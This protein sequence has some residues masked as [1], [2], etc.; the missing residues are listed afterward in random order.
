MPSIRLQIFEQIAVLLN[1]TGKPTTL[2]TVSHERTHPIETADLDAILIYA[3]DDAPKPLAGQE[4]KAP[5]TERQ[6]SIIC[7]CRALGTE[8]IT[9]EQAL[10]PLLVW[11][12]QQII[13]NE[14]FDGLANGVVEQRTVWLSREGEKPIAA[15]AIHF[16]V[17]YR[18]ARADPTKKS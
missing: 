11:T 6:L 12:L 14:T 5:L 1:A 16:T 17:K 13:G 7:E 9:P 15:A 8:S 4:Y 18:T 2:K 10:D 3:D